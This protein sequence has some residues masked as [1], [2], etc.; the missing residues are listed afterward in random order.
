MVKQLSGR[1][2]FHDAPAIHE[3]HPGGDF[4]RKA[5]FVRHDD[6]RH[7]LL[8]KAA[9]DLQHLAHHLRVKRARR[10]VKQHYIRLHRK[11][12]HDGNTLLLPAGKLGWIRA[13]TVRKTYA[14]KQYHGA[15][16]RFFF[17]ELLQ[18]HRRQREVL[19][20]RHVRK[21]VELLEHHA[22]LLP[23]LVDV[24]FRV[25]NIHPFHQNMTFRWNFKQVQRTQERGFARA[26]RA[27]HR[28]NFP[29]IDGFRD[30]IE[31]V[32]LTE[33]LFQP[34]H[35]DQRITLRHCEASFQAL[36]PL[37]RALRR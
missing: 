17:A 7:A 6:H 1:V 10:F 26:G 30:V 12:A 5:H 29:F 2:L 21:Q 23:K 16:V 37:P 11:R 35:L 14:R 22:H 27:D 8:R 18:L 20:D 3:Q 31:R 24:R 28:H 36:S 25:G 15:L 13:C 34:L 33:I 4:A 32:H 9:H 19:E